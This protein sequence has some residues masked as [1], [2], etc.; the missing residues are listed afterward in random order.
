MYVD[1]QCVKTGADS[2]AQITMYTI[3]S[4]IMKRNTT[5]DETFA[6]F[7]EK[8]MK[9]AKKGWAPYGEVMY[10]VNGVSQAMTF[11]TPDMSDLP[12]VHTHGSTRPRIMKYCI[13]G[14]GFMGKYVDI[15]RAD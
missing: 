4:A 6:E 14:E 5:T 10:Y 8:R 9:L 13:G 12:L 3:V 11:G 2:F 7:A 1:R 15:T